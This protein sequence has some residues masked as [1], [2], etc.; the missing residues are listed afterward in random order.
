MGRLRNCKVGLC[1]SSAPINQL[2][3]T[4]NSFQKLPY[5]EATLKCGVL[6]ES[7]FSQTSF[8]KIV[9]RNVKISTRN[10]KFG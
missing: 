6:F 5:S 9:R 4:T 8:I 10:F 2:F 1:Y 3:N 7:V